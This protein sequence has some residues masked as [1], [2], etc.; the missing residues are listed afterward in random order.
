MTAYQG[1][2]NSTDVTLESDNV[3]VATHAPNI[4]SAM[5][6]ALKK[7]Y[8]Q[9][10]GEACLDG[11]LYGRSATARKAEGNCTADF[12]KFL[13]W[14]KTE[15]GLTVTLDCPKLGR[16]TCSGYNAVRTCSLSGEWSKSNY[17][18]CL[19][20]YD[21]QNSNSESD[22]QER[23]IPIMRDIYFYG[24]IYSL[25]C[26]VIAFV[27]FM[28]F[29]NLWC[30]RIFIHVNLII[31]FILRY[32]TIIVMF[33]PFVTGRTSSYRDVD[34]LCKTVLVISQYSIMANI[35][36][37][38]VEGLYLH[39]RV[40]VAVFSKDPHFALY[41]FIGWGLP[42]VFMIAWSISTHYTHHIQCW[43][44]FS[45]KNESWII[46]VPIILALVLNL[47]F[48][49]NIIR[50]LVTKLA[51]SN[52]SEHVQ[53]RKAAKGIAILFP[54]LGITN[55]LFIIKPRHSG[56]IAESAY[57]ISNTVLQISQGFFVS[58][59][60]C[61]MSTEVQSAIKKRWGR[62]KISKAGGTRTSIPMLTITE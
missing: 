48:F 16:Y 57:Y 15:P 21:Q 28:V 18:E 47:I 31:S 37:M 33:E 4:T 49:I 6:D 40:A 39:N 35:F 2:E 51:T 3:R 13:C 12:D 36:W 1:F 41:G 58:L 22:P 43:G 42:L 23:I 19:E 7:L 55:L 17:T 60:Y 44:E 34:W 32:V 29:R 62:Y 26:L 14:P 38:F 11:V 46:L 50:V 8:K 9:D 24:G 54:L 30:R 61:F 53:M 56:P 10:G 45:Q 5:R 25:T 52:S 27:I 20:C 59:I